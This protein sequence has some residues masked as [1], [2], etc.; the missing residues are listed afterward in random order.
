MTVIVAMPVVRVSAKVVLEKGRGWS[1][2]DELILWTL[3]NTSATASSLALRMNLPRRVI[4]EVIVRMM[5]FRL[6]ELVVD[7]GGSA[8]RATE[9]GRHVVAGGGEIPALRKRLQRKVAFVVDRYTGAVFAKRDVQIARPAELESLRQGQIRVIS[10]TVS[11]VQPRTTPR[12]NVARFQE[13]L[14]RDE[15]LLYFDGD[16]L[17]ERDDEFML[18]TV[19][20]EDIRNLPER[21]PF[22][23][24]AKALELSRAAQGSPVE[25]VS[26]LA[27]P[28]LPDLPDMIPCLTGPDDLIFGGAEHR[29]AFEAAIRTAHKRLVIHSS[30]LRPDAFSTW[31]AD[32]K[33]AARRGVRIDIIWGAGRTDAPK[34]DTLA[35]A[36]TIASKIGADPV[37]RDSV[38]MHMASTGSHAKVILHDLPL[39]QWRAI[40]GSCNW[41]YTG[42]NRLELSLHLTHPKVVAQAADGL[43]R[44]VSRGGFP[45]SFSAELML[46]A[47]QLRS[48][49]GPVGAASVGL[50]RGQ[51]HETLLRTA[52]AAANGRFIIASDR[53]GQSA[54]QYGILPAETAAQSDSPPVVVF[55]QNS[56]PVSGSDA[57]DYVHEA[58]A[59]GVRL[60]RISHGFHAKFLLW[61]DDDVVIT[62]LNWGSAFVSAD[63]PD[64]ELGVHLCSPGIARSLEQ[65]LRLEWTQL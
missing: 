3:L 23:L 49:D 60:L 42:F 2:I 62:S 63:E 4:L 5:R 29:S 41:F 14:N 26:Q 56:G 12:E 46:L 54:F 16:T 15:A 25:I 53:L 6:V 20:G 57:A 27:E 11:G 21:A 24:R 36:A 59:R 47:G 10:P 52:G 33:N 17:I 35:A 61:G 19:D 65:R 50:V 51:M 30:F 32:L 44:L 43:S 28:D 34:A 38:R 7:E 1:A 45:P 58:A 48:R 64:V 31:L 18:L 39:G 13:V 8:F 37:L 55:G 22:D 9:L 40:I